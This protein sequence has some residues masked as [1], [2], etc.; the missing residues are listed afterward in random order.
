[1]AE[2]TKLT[3][4]FYNALDRFT[5]FLTN[6]TGDHRYIHEGKA[7]SFSTV[8]T[9]IAAAGVYDINITTP[10]NGYVHWRPVAFGTSANITLLELYEGAT[11]SATGGTIT[12][13]NRNRNK[14]NASTVTVNYAVT[15][16]GT[17]TFLRSVT[18]GAGGVTARAGGSSA[19]EV[20]EF[21]MKPSTNYL[22]R[23]TNIGSTT[24][25]TVYFTAFWYEETYGV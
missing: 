17:G 15:T 4:W 19:G 23:F 12:P 10:A 5:G 9:S 25:T 22:V 14:T 7:F 20:E 6:I 2:T 1:M 16:T 18:A 11:R 3:N 24:A 13:I 8:T 21:V